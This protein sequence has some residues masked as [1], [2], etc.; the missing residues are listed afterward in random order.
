[1]IYI[2]TVF[3]YASKL[4][5]YSLCIT[6]GTLLLHSLLYWNFRKFSIEENSTRT[7]IGKD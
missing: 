1:M 7:A 5:N 2:V 3:P 6:E 4:T